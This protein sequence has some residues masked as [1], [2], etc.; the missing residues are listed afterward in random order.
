MYSP[1]TEEVIEKRSRALNIVWA[2]LTFSIPV[3]AGV[4]WFFASSQGPAAQSSID[5]VRLALAGAAIADAMI[6]QFM[7][8]A[9]LSRGSLERV[10]GEN[11]AAEVSTDQ[12]EKLAE[13]YFAAVLIVLVLHES[14]AIFGL[15]DA[16]LSGSVDWLLIYAG[17]ALL[18]NFA[19][20]P[21]LR[22]FLKRIGAEGR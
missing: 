13:R 17:A 1:E 8:S 19:R 22:G 5:I 20:R 18:L 7:Y 12:L 11:R 10:L 21:D 16:F 4:G 9:M 15:V 3:Y 6:A 2:A 14:I